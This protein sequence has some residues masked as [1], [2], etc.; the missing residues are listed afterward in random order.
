MRNDQTGATG[1]G[2]WP[3]VQWA[4][5]AAPTPDEPQGA[6]PEA[7]EGL[8]Q[9]DGYVYDAYG[10][11]HPVYGGFVYDDQGNAYPIES[12][13]TGS[14]ATGES[15]VVDASAASAAAAADQFTFDRYATVDPS[16]QWAFGDDEGGGGSRSGSRQE[17]KVRRRRRSGIALAISLVLVLGV[18]YYVYNNVLPM[19]QPDPSATTEVA[20][21]DFPGPGTGS[22]EIVVNAGDAGATIGRT[23]EEAGVVATAS[24]FTRAYAAN[25]EAVGIQHGTYAMQLEMNAADAVNWLLDRD[26]KIELRVT[27]PEGHTVAQIF[28]VASSKTQIPVEDFEAAAE[29]PHGLG[30]PDDATAQLEGWLFPATYTVEPGDDAEAILKTMV[31]QTRT[32]LARLE[33]PEEDWEEVLNKASLVEREVNRQ[34]DRGKAARAIENRLEDGMTLGIDATLAYGL[35]KSGL[36]LTSADLQSDHPFNTRVHTGLPPTPIGSPGLAAIQAVIDPEPGPWLYWVTVDLLS[37]ETLFAVTYSE[38]QENVAKLQA[39]IAEN[40]MPE[41]S[42]GG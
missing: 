42:E 1:S 40:G 20:A 4:G 41:S 10:Y 8:V 26:N 22:V 34:D 31:S 9:P 28:K 32:Q 33:V 23:L 17:L 38:H 3:Q 24:A 25:P 13:V 29:D 21:D 16:A 19:F 39:W 11:A 37:G 27:I 30:V 18:G 6:Q 36:E 2:G 14:P 5:E 12:L 15:P 7:T 35:G